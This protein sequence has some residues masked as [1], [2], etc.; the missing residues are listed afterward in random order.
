MI[1][2]HKILDQ[3]I[4]Y[5]FTQLRKYAKLTQKEL[6]ALIGFSANHIWKFENG[7]TPIPLYV[8]NL[9]AENIRLFG[10]Y[11]SAEWLLSGQGNPPTLD[12]E[13]KNTI[14]THAHHIANDPLT[15]YFTHALSLTKIYRDKLTLFVAGIDFEPHVLAGT[16]II[17]PTV[18]V[19]QFNS[20]WCGFYLFEHNHSIIPVKLHQTASD[21]FEVTSL[22]FKEKHRVHLSNQR[23]FSVHPATGT[24]SRY[25][26]AL[27]DAEDI[28]H[29]L[30]NQ[31]MFYASTEARSLLDVD[32]A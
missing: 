20:N 29:I 17:A 11:V 14:D 15:H 16:F 2:S 24:L 13:F 21:V 8:L 26:I 28:A 10:I 6:G 25:H 9:L 4:S 18:E 19:N 23:L 22:H 27:S 12:A 7:G 3:H 5:R 30:Q 1:P 31:R 32:E